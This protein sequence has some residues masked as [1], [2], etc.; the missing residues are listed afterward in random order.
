MQKMRISIRPLA[1][2]VAL[3]LLMTAPLAAATACKG[4]RIAAKAPNTGAGQAIRNASELSAAL[5]GSRGGETFVLAPGNYGELAL[6]ADYKSPVTIRSANPKSPACFTG[7]FLEGANNI[8]LQNIYFDYVFS[9]GDPHFL[10]P[11]NIYESRNI[12]IVSSIFDGDIARGTNSEADGYSYGIGLRIGR[13]SNIRLSGNEFRKWWSATLAGQS[14]RVS[15][16]SNNIHTIR[17]DGINIDA[18]TGLVIEN[19]YIHDFGGA[20]GSQD[21]RDMIQIMRVTPKGSTDIVIR[22]NVFDMG[23]GDFTQTIWAGGDGKDLG[24]RTMRHRN[25]LVENNMIYNAHIHGI[26]IHGTDNISIRKNTLIHVPGGHSTPAINISSDSTSVVIEQNATASI[27]G[28]EGQ[29]G[30]AVLNNAII[31]DTSPSQ[32]G[33]YDRQFIYY[34]IGRKNGYNEY[35]V[36]PGSLVDRLNAGSTLAKNYPTRR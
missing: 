29:R 33:Y 14:A 7:M 23:R 19:N 21:H 25:V 27:I 6:H 15:Y 4:A 26:S 10:S 30:W 18:L 3:F 34:A 32:N 5:R 9:A 12:Q 17:S 20:A 36:R 22:K 24:D 11:F 8:V 2:V 13:S 28:H 1:L 31:Q 16:L 35:G